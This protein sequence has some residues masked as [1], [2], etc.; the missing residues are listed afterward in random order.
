VN[1]EVSF[2]L[3]TANCLNNFYFE[4]TAD[5]GWYSILEVGREASN[6]SL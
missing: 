6:S 4:A 5:N 2:R 3:D 1:L